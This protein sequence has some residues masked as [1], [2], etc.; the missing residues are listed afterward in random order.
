M[1]LQIAAIVLPYRDERVRGDATISIGYRQRARGLLDGLDGAAQGFP[2]I[3]DSL[4]A[5]RAELGLKERPRRVRSQLPRPKR[6]VVG[7]S[8]GDHP[9]GAVSSPHGIEGPRD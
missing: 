2:D 7:R 3:Q 1:A 6:G 9:S 5:A 4:S 8:V